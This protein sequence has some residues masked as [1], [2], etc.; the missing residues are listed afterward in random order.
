MKYFLNASTVETVKTLYRSLA[1]QHHPDRGGDTATMAEINRQY[2]AALR[3]LDG[4]E[5]DG[6]TYRYDAAKESALVETLRVLLSLPGIDID[7]VGRWLWI[8]GETRAV[9]DQLKAAGCRWSAEKGLWY[10]RPA[11]DARR[12]RGNGGSF[13]D[14]CNTYGA[15]RI[16]PKHTRLSA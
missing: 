4:S 2:E 3:R 6:R 12:W 11:E 7:L 15:S 5:T 8:S 16:V 9:K 1:M 14:I 10:W 13:E